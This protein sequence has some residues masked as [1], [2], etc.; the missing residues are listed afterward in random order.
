MIAKAAACN[1]F[2]AFAKGELRVEFREDNN[3]KTLDKTNIAS[4]LD[5]YSDEKNKRGGFLSGSMALAALETIK[6]GEDI[7]IDTNFGPIN[8]QMAFLTSLR[9]RSTTSSCSQR[10]ILRAEF[11]FGRHRPDN[12]QFRQTAAVAR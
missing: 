3:T 9:C 6:Y 1:F 12:E 11:N 2:A 8:M 5:Q 7:R 4:I 10:C